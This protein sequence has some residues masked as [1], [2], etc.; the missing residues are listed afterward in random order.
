MKARSD[1]SVPTALL[2]A[3]GGSIGALARWGVLTAIPL[4][5]DGF[6][7]ATLLVNVVGCLLIGA[8]ARRLAPATDVWFGVVTGCI[9][10]FTTFSA[11]ANEVWILVDT[12]RAPVALVYVAVTLAGG[13]A[14]VELGR[15]AAR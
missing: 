14:A 7:W 11:F 5:A 6:P 3:A 1:P 12:D 4:D 15:L 10:G 13:V 9:G 8:A 2:V